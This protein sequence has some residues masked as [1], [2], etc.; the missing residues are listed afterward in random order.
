MRDELQLIRELWHAQCD[1]P[2][3]KIKVPLRNYI[4]STTVHH[5]FNSFLKN[6]GVGQKWS[7]LMSRETDFSRMEKWVVRLDTPFPWLLRKQRAAG[8]FLAQTQLWQ[9][10]LPPVELIEIT[11]NAILPV[12]GA[13]VLVDLGSHSVTSQRPLS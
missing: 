12:T 1:S 13:L 4:P 11:R 6:S 10:P 9:V 7:H 8:S 3:R 2:A 5:F